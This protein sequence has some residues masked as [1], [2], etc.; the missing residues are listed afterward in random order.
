MKLIIKEYL[1]SLKERG[2]LDVILPNLLSQMGLRVFSRPGRGPRQFGVDIGAVG[3]IGGNVEKVFLLSVKPGNLGRKDWDTDVTSLRPSLNEIFDVYIPTHLPIE[4]KGLPVNICICIGGDIEES[5]RLNISQYEEAKSTNLIKIVEWDG[6]HLASWIEEHFLQEN[7]LPEE[8]RP[9][10]RKSLALLDEAHA[11]FNHFSKLLRKFSQVET[12]TRKQDLTILRQMNICLWILF[13]WAR[14]VNNLESCF[15]AAERTLLLSWERS[16]KY[17]AIQ[18]KSNES[19]QQ[20]FYST[21]TTY[22]IIQRKYVSKILPF[23]GIKHGLSKAV[24]S[25]DKLDINLKLF[26]VLGRIAIAGMWTKWHLDVAREA[27]E[28]TN[29][30]EE[31]INFIC[32]QLKTLINNNPMLY[33]PFTDDQSID[34]FLTVLLWSFIDGNEKDIGHWISKIFDKSLFSYKVHGPY[35]CIHRDYLALL[36]HPERS[37][38][39]YR[40]SA[41]AG[42][43]L[44]PTIGLWAALLKIDE[45]YRNVQKAKV[46]NLSHCTFQFWYPD[47]ETEKRWC[48]NDD[49]HGATFTNIPIEHDAPSFLEALWNECENQNYFNELS[50]MKIGY[51]PLLLVACRHYRFPVPIHFTLGNRVSV[52]EPKTHPIN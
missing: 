18:N 37:D 23:M 35:P 32:H 29:K 9:L 20:A 11:S 22:Q 3:S 28:D 31:E 47:E 40:Q 49:L 2:E 8:V 52:E 7:L 4:L 5:V 36:E 46:E 38:D 24:C 21:H 13:S 48:K 30:F 16:K 27:K 39:E 14:A 44:Y 17:F 1:S 43:I 45:L 12:S 15:L 25:S 42:S 19:I 33:T 50:C 51:W 10:L 34:I 41:T 6:D 26:D